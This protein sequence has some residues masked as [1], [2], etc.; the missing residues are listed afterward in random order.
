MRRIVLII[1]LL[2]LAGGLSVAPRQLVSRPATNP[3][4][5]H[6]ESAHVHPAAM[7]PDGS[8]LL[9]VNTAD[10][11]LSVFSLTGGTPVRVAEIPV[12]LEPVTVRALDDS[13]A[14]VVNSLSD[15]ISVVDL[16]RGHTVETF[17]VGDSPSDVVFA[18]GKAYVSI[19]EEDRIQIYHPVTLAHLGTI[20]TNS[21][22]PRALARNAAG[23]LVFAA[24]LMPGNRTSVLGATEIPVDSFPEDFDM[25]MDPGL[26]PAPR[27][28]LII[29]ES[30][31]SWYDMYGNLWNSKAKYT[32][33]DRDVVEIST[34]TD[35]VTRAFSGVGTTLFGIAVSPADG[36]LGVVNTE[37]RNLLR[38]EPRLIGYVVETQV[39]WVSTAGNVTLR[40]LDPHIDYETLPGTQA[41]ADS[42]IAI[43]TTIAFSGDGLRAYITSFGTDKLAVLVP[44]GGAFSTIRARVPTVAGPSGVV[45]DDAR[46][47]LYVVGRFR[48]Q[49][50]TLS[51]ATFAEVALTTIGMDPTPDV[52]VNG[53]RVFYSGAMSAHGD[54]SCASCHV[55]GDLDGLAWDLG[56]PNGA[57]VPP[58]G[59]NPL[60]LAG[61]HP[62]KGPMVTQ[63]LRGMTN[64]EP[65][66]WRGDRTN[67]SAFNGAFVSLLGK[68]APLADS[69]MTAFNDFVLPM[70]MAPNPSQRLDRGFRDA[71]P[72]VP[73]AQ[74]GRDFFLST[75]VLN[76]R[77]CESCHDEDNH[78]P[79][80]NRLMVHR[81]TILEAQ[82]LKV[83]QLRNIYRKSGF[84]DQ[85]GVQSLRG[86]GY[87]HDG[88]DDSPFKFLQRSQFTF[89]PNPT[90]ADEERRDMESYLLSFDTG[91]APAVGHQVTFTGANNADPNALGRVDTLKGQ[92]ALDYCDLIAKGRVEQFARGWVYQGADLWK[93]DRMSEADI[94][95]AQLVALAAD[96]HRAVTITGV[97]KG[98]GLRIGIDRDLDGW[99]DSDEVRSGYDPANPAS[100]PTSAGV[101]PPAGGA[102]FALGSVAPNPFRDGVDVSFSLGRGARVDAVVFDLLGR[103]VRTVARG[104]WMEAGPQSL[105]WDG[106]TA[107]GR[108]APAGVYFLRV[109]VPEAGVKWTRPVVRIH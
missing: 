54:Q 24:S 104:R 22:M 42:A 89:N 34:A 45:V 78:G 38:F 47:Q 81:D 49:L 33:P 3:D 80:T 72:G 17:R 73:S 51:T 6:F 10:N 26:P 43:P 64:T 63:T 40:K 32:M 70:A 9:V 27:Q 67:L 14:W 93:S 35:A 58:P 53:R 91:M 96:P 71:P 109:S 82:D 46:G 92:A 105:R 30:A 7:T 18:N 25:P 36:R 20:A 98:S 1:V 103:E 100:H 60:D 11:R 74:R 107:E 57:F 108:G 41:E 13:T 95:T 44:T 68:V 87:S 85:V 23:T 29:Q 75:P 8:K 48:N 62:M 79:G 102:G 83:P 31:G 97:P 94:T 76:G 2:V 56:D 77:T 55:F 59:P 15:N 66:H 39:S 52:I 69:Q 12:G 21:R 16:I 106:R 65:F 84:V 5:V 4:F 50:Q 88:S 90:A 61:F 28:G 19:T 99:W 86:F 101:A 37:G